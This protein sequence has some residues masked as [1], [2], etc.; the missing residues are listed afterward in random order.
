MEVINQTMKR[1]TILV[2]IH[3]ILFLRD[4]H[5]AKLLLEDPDNKQSNFATELQ[6]SDI[7]LKKRFL[8]IT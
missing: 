4:I 3:Y 5:E 6:N 1:L 8:N 7:K 2:N